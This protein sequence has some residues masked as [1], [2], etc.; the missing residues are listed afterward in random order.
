MLFNRENTFEANSMKFCLVTHIFLKL[1]SKV[2]LLVKTLESLI[3][4]YLLLKKL[5]QFM[6]FSHSFSVIKHVSYQG[7]FLKKLPGDLC[8]KIVI[9]IQYMVD[10]CGA[11]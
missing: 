5:Q 7:H 11:K 9:C 1:F 6:C 8:K 4:I 2:I 3:K 10:Y